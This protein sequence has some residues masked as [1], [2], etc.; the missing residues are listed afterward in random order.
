MSVGRLGIAAWLPPAVTVYVT[1]RCPSVRLS[2][3]S[4]QRQRR[5]AGLLIYRSI[6]AVRARAAASVDAMIRGGSTHR[7]CATAATQTRLN[8]SSFPTF[9]QRKSGVADSIHT[10]PSNKTYWR[11]GVGGVH[12]IIALNVFEAVLLISGFDYY[13]KA[14]RLSD[15]RIVCCQWYFNN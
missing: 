9:C 1:V 13:L 7:T 2:V 10:A 8:M 14:G 12:W 3:P 5:A 11:V 6:S 4:R 15:V